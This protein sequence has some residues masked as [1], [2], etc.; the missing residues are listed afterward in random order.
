MNDSEKKLLR[1]IR[2]EIHNTGT[3]SKDSLEKL[4]LLYWKK[5]KDPY[6]AEELERFIRWLMRHRT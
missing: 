3:L 2:K 4:R 5:R 1:K 6:E